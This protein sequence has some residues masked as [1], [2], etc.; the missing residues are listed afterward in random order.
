MF[1][2]VRQTQLIGRL[3]GKVGFRSAYER[4]TVARQKQLKAF[5]KAADET[6]ATQNARRAAAAKKWHSAARE[7]ASTSNLRGSPFEKHGD[8]RKPSGAWALAMIS[9]T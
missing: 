1:R 4:E 6:I 2:S 5:S 3:W 9:W 8:L 7:I